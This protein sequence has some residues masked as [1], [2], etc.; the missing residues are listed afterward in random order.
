M[1]GVPPE[2]VLQVRSICLALTEAREE[3][4]WIGT[5]WKIRSKTFAHLLAVEGGRPAAYAKALGSPGPATV[6]TFR[7]D[8]P[9]IDETAF[10]RL[11]FFKPVW[12]HDIAGMVL[13][14]Q[15]EWDDCAA[16]LKASYRRLA[17][18]RLAV[19]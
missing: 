4:A 10:S 5:R 6:L 2:I 18:K 8:L 1:T 13:D 7:S 15:T 9:D 14:G 19:L 3:Q 16:L 17:P 12:W 11:P